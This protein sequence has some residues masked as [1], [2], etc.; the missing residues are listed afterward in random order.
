MKMKTTYHKNKIVTEAHNPL[1]SL[2]LQNAE[3]NAH[4]IGLEPSSNL[5]EGKE[6]WPLARNGP[7]RCP[8]K[9]P[10]ITSNVI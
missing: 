3:V 9:I 2:S 10:S 8:I 5:G 6:N 4:Y 1:G 7:Q